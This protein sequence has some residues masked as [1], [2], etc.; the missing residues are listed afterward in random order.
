MTLN[1]ATIP[2]DGTGPEV[3]D[4]ALG[5]LNAVASCHGLD[6]TV[7]PYPFGAKHYLETG[8]VLTESDLDALRG[9]DAILLGAVGH[10]DVKPGVLERGLL[11]ELRFRFDQYINLRPVRL[12]EGVQTPLRG[13]GPREID[14]VVVRENTED[15]YAGGGGV[16]RR[17]TPQEVA[18]QEMLATRFGVERCIRYA[19]DL[20]RSR[21]R[22][23]L[24]L[25]HK[26]NVLTY[27]GDLWMRT[28][29]EVGSEYGDI[30][31][32]Y[33]HIDA[34]CM[35]LVTSPERYDTIVTANM[36]GDIITDLGAAIA[37][38][39][40]IAA[41]GNL[42]PAWAGTKSATDGRGFISGGP[43][44]FEP[45]HGSSPDIAGQNRANPLAAIDTIAMLLGEMGRSRRDD[46]MTA[47]GDA[48]NAAV[49]AV[50]PR[51]DGRRLDRSG[52]G[53][54]EIGQMVVGEVNK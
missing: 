34:A 20:A 36:F 9:H 3:I 33:H 10:P 4:E 52:F 6:V 35:Y 14:L 21:E 15:L 45:V 7:T 48:V 18:T 51:F 2:G 1:L 40:G 23:L 25:V 31:R 17:G 26:T 53:T 43:S 47:A 46:A 19:F 30:E 39:M 27:A 16:A 28:F 13:K 32:E 12:Y 54:R 41:S 11:L 49:R 50:T 38:G 29:E 44:M 22:K 8:E 24:T 5:V 42:N 37:G